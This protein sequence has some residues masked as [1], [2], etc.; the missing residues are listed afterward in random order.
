MIFYDISVEFDCCANLI[1]N[2]K[3]PV[4]KFTT[5]SITFDICKSLVKLEFSTKKLTL[6]ISSHG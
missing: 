5:Y 4:S 3:T 1:G 2:D 6:R